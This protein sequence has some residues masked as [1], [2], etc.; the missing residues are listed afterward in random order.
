MSAEA[1]AGEILVRIMGQGISEMIR[2]SGT[3]AMVA[4][5]AAVS[6]LTFCYAVKVGGRP[7]EIARNPGGMAIITIPEEKLQEFKQAAKAYKL[8]FFSVNHDCT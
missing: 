3:G 7:A 6:L 4:G 1:E 2:V 8:Q 5:R